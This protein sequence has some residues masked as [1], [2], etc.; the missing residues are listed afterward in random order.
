MRFFPLPL[1]L[2]GLL[3][4][5]GLAPAAALA[6]PNDGPRTSYGSYGPYPNPTYAPL[7][8]NPYRNNNNAYRSFNNNNTDRYPSSYGYPI[9]AE[10]VPYGPAPVRSCNR[11]TVLTGA[12][13]GGGLGA[14]LATNSRNRLW[15]LPIGA[16]M[17]GI[18]GGVM[19]G[20]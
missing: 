11:G 15:S 1:A 20:C 6:Y 4:C 12:A 16:A 9:A 5:A 14:I 13:I 10:A 8:V 19:S 2:V 3:G 18:L 17:G 7:P